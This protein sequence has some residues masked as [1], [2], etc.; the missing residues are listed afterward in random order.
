MD[1]VEIC[2]IFFLQHLHFLTSQFGDFVVIFLGDRPQLELY[3]A[4]AKIPPIV[5]RKC[6]LLAYRF[7]LFCY[8][9]DCRGTH[10]PW[11]VRNCPVSD[12]GRFLAQ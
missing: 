12:S 6:D 11:V 1:W 5:S 9:F 10:R 8:I 2:G 3:I 4:T 7:N